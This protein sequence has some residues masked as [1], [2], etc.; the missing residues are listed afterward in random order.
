[1]NWAREP[2][3][4][5]AE[6]SGYDGL[7]ITLRIAGRPETSPAQF[8]GSTVKVKLPGRDEE[9][10]MHALPRPPR[11]RMPMI[12]YIGYHACVD[13]MITPPH[14][15]S[16]PCF[17][18]LERR[19]PILPEQDMEK[20]KMVGQVGWRATNE[21]PCPFWEAFSTQRR[22]H[23][24]CKSAGEIGGGG[25]GGKCATCK[26]PWAAEVARQLKDVCFPDG[27]QPQVAAARQ[28]QAGGGRRKRTLFTVCGATAT[29]AAAQ[30][31]PAAPAR[32]A[33]AAA[34]PAPAPAGAERGEEEDVNMGVPQETA[35]EL[36]EA[37]R[38]AEAEGLLD[39]PGTGRI[40]PTGRSS[41]SGSRPGSRATNDQKPAGIVKIT[42]Q[43][44]VKAAAAASGGHKPKKSPWENGRPR[45]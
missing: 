33:A 43:A 20:G 27:G 17:G 23:S 9:R 2:A 6:G 14:T 26:I 39:E 16:E 4:L 11:A 28:A 7:M 15:A 21:R 32:A 1:L 35:E 34:S 29:G 12:S 18:V 44:S 25:C 38:A 5:K 31:A 40:S 37:A 10:E 22:R 41:R 19:A 30:P 24:P 45:G 8:A 42:R 13:E 36:E 3:R